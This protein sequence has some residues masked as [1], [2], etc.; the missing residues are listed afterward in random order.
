MAARARLLVLVSVLAVLLPACSYD[1]S[2]PGLFP[3]PETRTTDA[4]PP[5]TRFPPQQTNPELPV[6]GEAIWVSGGQLSVTFRLAVHA[7]RR[8]ERATVLDWSVTPVEASG[9][10]FGD[11]LPGIDLGLSRASRSD[12]NVILLDPGTGQAYQPLTHRSRQLFNH[13]LCTP[14]WV[15]QQDLRIG[16]TRLLQIAYPELPPG[17]EFIDVGLATVPPFA[18]V[19]VTPRGSVP[20]VRSAT[21]LARPAGKTSTSSRKITVRYS[22]PGRGAQTLQIN[23]ILAAPGRTSVEWTITSV[24]DQDITQLQNWGPPISSVPPGELYIVTG[25]PASGPVLVAGR[26]GGQ[27]RLHAS[28]VATEI[29][30]QQAYECLCTDVGLWANGLRRAGGTVRVTTNYPALPRDVTAI[31]IE[32]PG[33]GTFRDVVVEPAPDSASRSGPVRR[34]PDP[35]PVWSYLVEDPPRGWS[36]ADWPAPEPDP[37]QLADYRVLVETVVRLPGER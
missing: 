17:V 22:D 3:S 6:V 37:A 2:E 32:L 4:A 21:D 20:T 25:N 35:A 7:V 16:Q 9:F 5:R 24:A 26:G 8:V 36:T 19:P 18:H 31:D 11:D 33:F 14:P 29:N 15:I 27:Q 13:C 10:E 12:V 28:W 30:G 1:P 34:G 23:R